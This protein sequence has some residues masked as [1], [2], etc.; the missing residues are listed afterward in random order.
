M[1]PLVKGRFEHKFEQK[2]KRCSK[3]GAFEMLT[4]DYHSLVSWK[5]GIEKGMVKRSR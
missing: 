4:Y 3:A 1:F 5:L 2:N